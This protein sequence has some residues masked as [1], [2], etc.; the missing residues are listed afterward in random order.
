MVWAIRPVWHQIAQ[1]VG[2]LRE[3]ISGVVI[4]PEIPMFEYKLTVATS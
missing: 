3:E 4:I 2:Y 1:V